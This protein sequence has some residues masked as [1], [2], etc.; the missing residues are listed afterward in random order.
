MIEGSGSVSLTNGSGSGR[1][2]NIPY[3]SYESGSAT[4]LYR[5]LLLF[6]ICRRIEQ[7][8]GRG[9]DG[10]AC[11]GIRVGRAARRTAER[12][13]AGRRVSRHSCPARGATSRSAV[14]SPATWSE[15]SSARA[16]PPSGTSQRS[17]GLASTFIG[18]ENIV[19][20]R[21]PL[22][23]LIQSFFFEVDKLAWLI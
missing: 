21:H 19:Q 22:R 7:S 17:P 6:Y 20:Q 16:A 15:Q 8:E 23:F 12:P 1:P 10:P 13:A 4:L 5:L 9:C 18:K 2:K 14:S 3:G 11:R